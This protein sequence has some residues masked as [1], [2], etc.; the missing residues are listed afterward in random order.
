LANQRCA[1]FVIDRC[2]DDTER[3]RSDA[4]VRPRKTGTMRDGIAPHRKIG[5][6]K[7]FF[8]SEDSPRIGSILTHASCSICAMLLH[9][10]PSPSAG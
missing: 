10:N 9:A 5:T 1:A 6:R 7:L 3:F 2:D 8:F 4:V